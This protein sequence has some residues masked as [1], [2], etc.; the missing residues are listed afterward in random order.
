M[1]E[2]PTGLSPLQPG[3]GTYGNFSQLPTTKTEVASYPN[4]KGTTQQA[5][6]GYSQ[7]D[8]SHGNYQLPNQN[9]WL[10]PRD[11]E[12]I[13]IN[14]IVRHNDYSLPTAH[15]QDLERKPKTATDTGSG[16][17]TA[18]CL[19]QTRHTVSDKHDTLHETPSRDSFQWDS[20]PNSFRAM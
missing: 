9:R 13:G 16:I 20:G 2:E 10:E 4:C 8:Y 19:R 7:C 14:V 3:A 18:Y 12:T 5:H 11:N 1:R 17:G 6:Y 15:Q